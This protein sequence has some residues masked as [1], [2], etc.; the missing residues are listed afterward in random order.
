MNAALRTG[1]GRLRVKCRRIVAGAG[2]LLFLLL[3]FGTIKAPAAGQVLY[4]APK[5]LKLGQELVTQIR[6]LAPEASFT[7]SGTLYIKTKR[8]P[9]LT[10]AYTC[11]VE[12]TPTH[13][14]SYYSAMRGT[15]ALPGFS[16]EH[17]AG[18]P[19]IYRDDAGKILSGTQLDVPFAG[20][21]FWLSDLGLEF[22]NWP[23]Q[24][25]PKWEMTRTVG[26]KVLESRNPDPQSIGYSRVIS[27][28]HDESLGIVRA[29]AYDASGKLLKEFRPTELQK[30]NGRR[31]LKEM[32][33]ENV[34]TDS[35]TRL[36]FEL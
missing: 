29:E 4:D 23:E 10:V 3:G 14:T 19:N 33:M 22:F 26:C 20:S 30:V 5:A 13:W 18:N 6:A 16:V 15:N 31:E 17:R 2:I 1:E 34:Q 25:V 9:L 12:I 36:E 28:I 27:W 11:R 8:Q 35:T 32:E 21:D 24:R 7:N